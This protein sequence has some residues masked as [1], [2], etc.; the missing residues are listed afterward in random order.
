METP[1]TSPPVIDQIKQHLES[2]FELAKMQGIDK[3]SVFI[4]ELMTG[5]IVIT[6]ALLAFILAS[7]TLALY[8]AQVLGSG[9]EGFACVTVIYL[10]LVFVAR[11]LKLSFQRLFADLF[12][13][14]IFKKN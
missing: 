14:K 12:I 10:L 1:N 13:Q 11:L 2:R 3:A 5:I 6:I 8:L 7:I 4:A 9:W